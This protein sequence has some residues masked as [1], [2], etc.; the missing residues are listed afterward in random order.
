[1]WTE[2]GTLCVEVVDHGNWVPP[3]EPV[4]YD[5]LADRGRGIPLMSSMAEAVLIH[6]DSRGSRVLLRHPVAEEHDDAGGA[7]RGRRRY[8]RGVSPG[9]AG[10]GSVGHRPVG[11][12]AGLAQPVPVVPG[13]PTP[14]GSRSRGS[15]VGVHRPP[16]GA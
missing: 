12:Q 2:P 4:A 9:P 6:H 14:S 15:G 5:G 16:T 13:R 1:M 11:A 3:V 10:P 7:R 8:V